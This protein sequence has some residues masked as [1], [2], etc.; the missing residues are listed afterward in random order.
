MGMKVSAL[1]LYNSLAT[2]AVLGPVGQDYGFQHRLEICDLDSPIGLQEIFR[3]HPLPLLTDGRA[4]NSGY[5]DNSISP[6]GFS[7]YVVT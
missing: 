5:E 4:E 1:K 7:Y 6:T 3:V 2:R